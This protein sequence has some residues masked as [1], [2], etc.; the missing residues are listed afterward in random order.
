MLFFLAPL[1]CYLAGLGVGVPAAA[2]AA[3]TAAFATGL[4]LG[5]RTAAVSFLGE[6]M[7]AVVLCHLALLSRPALPREDGPSVSASEAEWYPAGRILAAAAAMAGALAFL[8]LLLIGSSFSGLANAVRE[9]V[10]TVPMPHL[11]GLGGSKLGEPEKAALASILLYALPAASAVLWLGGFVLNLWLA[12]K[13]T[14]I[15]GRLVRPLPD[16]TLMRFPRGFGAALLIALIGTFASGM[17]RLAAIGVAGALVGAYLLMGLAIIHHGTRTLP[18][19]RSILWAVYLSLIIFNTWAAIP[20]ALV[21]IL[22]PL[23][24]YRRTEP[25]P[26]S[27]NSKVPFSS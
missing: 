7:P 20:I 18:A 25:E 6:G 23:L 3:V 9:I 15:S 4:L 11:P 27:G 19:R 16:L 5:P 22:E 21:A 1:P 13:I 24:W 14:Q 8:S 12:A 10:D 17:A 26:G 2:I